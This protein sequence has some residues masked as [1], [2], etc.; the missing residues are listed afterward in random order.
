MQF[1][2][3]IEARQSIRAY[4]ASR[5]I[6]EEQLR[7]IVHAAN[8]APSAGNFQAYEIYVVRGEEKHR[9]LTAA[10]F[11]Q[12]FVAQ[13]RLSLVFCTNPARC[14][15]PGAEGWAIQDAVIATTFA[16]LAIT[17]L[18]LATCWVAAFKADEIAKVVDAPAGQIP[19]SL[20]PIGYAAEQPER[21]SRRP[22]E[23]LVHEVK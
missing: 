21:T 17:D 9:E 2:E 3:L 4:D 16:H 12:N 6:T 15:Y 10:T 13:A 14:Q 7:A 18:G 5:E 11:N 22:L 23:E 8:R 1:S 19:V 20:L